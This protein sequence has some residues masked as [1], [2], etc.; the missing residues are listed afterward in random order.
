MEQA[1]RSCTEKVQLKLLKSSSINQLSWFSNLISNKVIMSSFASLL[2]FAF[3]LHA[4][5]CLIYNFTFKF[6]WKMQ[7]NFILNM[8]LTI[9]IQIW[10]TDVQPCVWYLKPETQKGKL[11]FAQRN[12]T[13]QMGRRRAVIPE[14][15]LNIL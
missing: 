3:K 8:N 2:S 11:A 10:F 1:S 13:W 14:N 9:W 5:P 4:H 7:H 6:I 15:K 12:L